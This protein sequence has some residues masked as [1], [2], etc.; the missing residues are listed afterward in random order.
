MRFLEVSFAT[1]GFNDMM[2]RAEHAL[3]YASRY[4][5]VLLLNTSESVYNVDF[6]EYFF[7]VNRRIIVD[8]DW[9]QRILSS[10]TERLAITP[11]NKNELEERGLLNW[12]TSYTTTSILIP[13]IDLPEQ[14]ISYRSAG[15]ASPYVFLRDNFV[16]TAKLRQLLTARHEELLENTGE[17]YVSIQIRNT[18][19]ACDYQLL[20]Q[21]NKKLIHSNAVHI[22]T[23]DKDCLQFFD[24]CGVKYCNL[25]EFPTGENRNLHGSKLLSGETKFLDMLSDLYLM[26]KSKKILSNS[27]GGFI[28]LAR[29]LHKDKTNPNNLFYF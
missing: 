15:G 2:S 10:C 4:D 5:R 14:L 12:A 8:K 11:K 1:C 19:H 17:D 16:A 27:K 26:S 18:D 25:C 6:G 20:Y 23:D 21:E 29:D 13:D 9:I 7:S 22:A 28:R 24:Q 3:S